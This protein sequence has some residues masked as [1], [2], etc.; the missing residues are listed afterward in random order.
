MS[1]RLW[2]AVI[3][4]PVVQSVLFGLGIVP[5]LSFRSLASHLPLLLPDLVIASVVMAAPVSWSIA[6]RL[7][8][9]YWRERRAAEAL[10]A[11]R[12]GVSRAPS[13]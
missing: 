6:P 11:R 3:I 12:K 10:A 1:T 13:V 7:M 4:Y 9:R 2:I 5:M 8:L